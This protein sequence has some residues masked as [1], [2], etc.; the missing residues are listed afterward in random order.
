MTGLTVPFVTPEAPFVVDQSLFVLL[1]LLRT[2]AGPVIMRATAIVPRAT[3]RRH[4]EPRRQV[5]AE[6]LDSGMSTSP[7]QPAG[8][9]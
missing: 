4:Q 8:Q 3:L 9:Y 1:G 5:A 2:P 6:F 7:F